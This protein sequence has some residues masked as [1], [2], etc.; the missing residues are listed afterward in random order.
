MSYKAN[1][2]HV[3]KLSG[4]W[5]GNER[6]LFICRISQWRNSLNCSDKLKLGVERR[7][8]FLYGAIKCARISQALWVLLPVNQFLKIVIY[9][10]FAFK[11]NVD[12]LVT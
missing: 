6:Y 10:A 8:L 4:V 3:G 1:Y 11:K 12:L 2:L 5:H 7:E 9:N